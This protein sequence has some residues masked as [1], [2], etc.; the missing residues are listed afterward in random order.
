[1]IRLPSFTAPAH[2]NGDNDAISTSPFVWR[3][4]KLETFGE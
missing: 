2:R 3:Q 1:M 4:V